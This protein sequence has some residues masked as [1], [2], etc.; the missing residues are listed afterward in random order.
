MRRVSLN[1]LS[2]GLLLYYSLRSFVV[3]SFPYIIIFFSF[4]LYSLYF[5]HFL[6]FSLYIFLFLTFFIYL[7]NTLNIHFLNSVP[8]SSVSIKYVL[9]TLYALVIEIW[10]LEV[11]GCQFIFIAFFLEVYKLFHN[12]LRLNTLFCFESQFWILRW[13]Y[14]LNL[15]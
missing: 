2:G 7:F 9:Q 14:W 6:L 1:K 8:K 3:E 10:V 15:F 13:E 4:L 12:F 11:N 5:I